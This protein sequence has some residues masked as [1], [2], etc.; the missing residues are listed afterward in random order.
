LSLFTNF[1]LISLIWCCH[2][3]LFDQRRKGETDKTTGNGILDSAC[4]SQYVN[5]LLDALLYWFQIR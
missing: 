3:K 5:G 1:S 2:E 4:Y